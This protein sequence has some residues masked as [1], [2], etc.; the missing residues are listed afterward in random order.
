[1][2]NNP[3]LESEPANTSSIIPRQGQDQR[4]PIRHVPRPTRRVSRLSVGVLGTAF[5]LGIA[6]GAVAYSHRSPVLERHV[7]GTN[8]IRVHVVLA[9]AATV[10]VLL[11]QVRRARK[12]NQRGPSPWT[13]PFSSRAVTRLSRTFRLSPAATMIR[14]VPMALLVLVLLYAPCRMGMQVIGGLDPNSTVNAWGG[15]TYA[16]ALLAHWLDCVI[17]FYVAAFLLARLLVPAGPARQYWLSSCGAGKRP[18]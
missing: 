15:P 4:G 5:L 3:R 17:G 18:G 9:V 8:A 13:A 6:E 7:P 12:R 14:A 16:G 10:V 2:T 11:I 1:M